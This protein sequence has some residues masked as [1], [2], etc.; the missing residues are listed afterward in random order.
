MD[1]TDKLAK[2]RL[3]EVDSLSQE[4]HSVKAAILDSRNHNPT[5]LAGSCIIPMKLQKLAVDVTKVI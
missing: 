3:V 4:T 5:G 1:L 2:T